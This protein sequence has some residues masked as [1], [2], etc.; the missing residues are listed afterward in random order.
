MLVPCPRFDIQLSIDN[1]NPTI[2]SRIDKK[3]IIKNA[4]PARVMYPF[5]MYCNLF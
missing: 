2:L 5:F 4:Y 3:P 1:C